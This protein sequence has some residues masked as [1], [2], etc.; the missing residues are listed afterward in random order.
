MS[1][2]WKP[3]KQTSFKDREDCQGER[4]DP[5]AQR[6][7]EQLEANGA[8]YLGMGRHRVTMQ[9]CPEYVIKI[10]WNEGGK[11]ANCKEYNI[12]R[13]WVECKYPKLYGAYAKCVLGDFEGLPI[14]YMETVQEL[15]VEVVRKWPRDIRSWA[16][17]DNDGAQVGLNSANILVSWDYA[18][19]C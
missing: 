15:H 4:I 18:G 19:F 17:N 6:L 9:L 5:V 12:Y 11:K 10:P 1:Y 3:I 13:D 14:L 7:I 2:R 8:Q 16:Y